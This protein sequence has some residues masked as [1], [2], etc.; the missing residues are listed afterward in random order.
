MRHSCD[1]LD[2]SV[3]LL[4]KRSSLQMHPFLANAQQP[5]TAPSHAFS[6]TLGHALCQAY[7][8]RTPE[9]DLKVVH[10]EVL[11]VKRQSIRFQPYRR[12][13]IKVDSQVT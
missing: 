8:A 12:I 9:T 7:K 2:F 4:V 11:L 6:T 3:A 1:L 5:I 10:Q 13:S